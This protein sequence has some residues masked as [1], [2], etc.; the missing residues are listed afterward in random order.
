M[1]LQNKYKRI[2]LDKIIVERDARQRRVVYDAE[3]KFINSDGLLE[4]IEARGVYNPIIVTDSLVLVAGERRLEASRTLGLPDI[5]CRYVSDLGITEG[6]IIE[7]EENLKRID[8]GWRDRVMAIAELHE[9]YMSLDPEWDRTRTAEVLNEAR[10]SIYLRVAQ[11]LDSPRIARAATV[12]EAYNILI[13]VDARAVDDAMSTID[14]IGE[15]IFEPDVG[16]T[17][18][19]PEGEP[20]EAATRECVLAKP[21]PGPEGL[22]RADFIK[23]AFEYT[24]P[25]FNLIHCDFPYGIGVFGG[26]QSG[27]TRH[28]TY[29]DAEGTYYDLLESLCRN[30]DRIA[31]PSCHL[32]FWLPAD[33]RRQCLTLEY[34]R[35]NAPSLNF[36]RSPL[37]WHKTDNAGIL[38]DPKRTPR[39]VYETAIVASREDRLI[40]QAVADAYGAPTDKTYHPSTKPEPVLRHF[41]RM[42]VDS[43]T[44]LLDP[45]CGSG[46]ALR[47]A[48]SLGAKRVV[49][50]ELD[51]EHFSAAQTALRNF[52]ALR[53]VSA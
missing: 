16:T 21:A 9:I 12:R 49:G 44:E 17:P 23:W 1:E 38:S 29:G 11:D 3:G 5:P 40:I 28:Q 18:S 39:H 37:I 7:L 33:I 8:L 45:T 13:R 32:V 50:L 2:P 15:S 4:S 47:A 52:R 31:T 51:E 22:L 48:E 25:K 14:D 10:L 41:F 53:R 24:G 6:K 46:S 35:Q 42:F 26:D 36:W 27:R 20:G 34:F 19:G 43:G 30:L